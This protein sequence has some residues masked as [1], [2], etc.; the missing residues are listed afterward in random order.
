MLRLAVPALLV[1]FSGCAGR[2]KV[3]PQPQVEPAD[4]G[5]VDA[6]EPTPHLTVPD[7]CLGDDCVPVLMF[8]A[9]IDDASAAMFAQAVMLSV[10]IGAEALV[11]VLDSGGGSFDAAMRMVELIRAAPFPVHCLVDGQASSSAFFL[12][13]ACT[14]RTATV[15]SR[16]LV[17]EV[18]YEV[19]G[20]TKLTR[21][22]MKSY[23]REL[24]AD[25]DR[26]LALVA[27]RMGMKQSDLEAKVA[28]D[29]WV[30]S[31]NQA[32]EAHALDRVVLRGPIYVKE[33]VDSH[34]K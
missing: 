5:T 23:I 12:L 7:K 6:P 15:T 27:D 8:T 9:R 32:L 3:P 24:D 30:M 16:L 13:Q 1:A 18:F 33:L 4:A 22:T 31:P 25:N 14:T 19:H 20:D 34:G 17:H 2:V 11:V 28:Y 21:S 10:G 26:A 29:D